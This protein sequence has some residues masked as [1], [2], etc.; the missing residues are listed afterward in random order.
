MNE[1]QHAKWVNALTDQ[2]KDNDTFTSVEIDTQG[3]SYAE[4]AAVFQNVPANFA[5]LAIQESDALAGNGGV[6][7]SITGLV[8]GTSLA[9]SGSASALP[10]AA[11]GDDKI[12]VFQIDLRDRK[13]YLKVLATAGNG[14]GTATEL[15]AIARLS[16]AELVPIDA[17][18]MGAAQVLR[19]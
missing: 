4:I 5:A 14:G 6:Y 11:T 3:F 17:A 10:T 18:G 7:A 9:I 15:T 16:R 13:R 12:T 1:A 2:S 19:V 8:V